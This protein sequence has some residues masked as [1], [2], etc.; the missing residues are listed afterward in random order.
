M[1]NIEKFILENRKSFD[2]A[3][4]PDGIWENI[5]A[6]FDEEQQNNR[7]QKK[8]AIRTFVS[9][10]A[11]LVMI[12]TAGILLYKTRENNKQDYSRV[13]PVLAQKQMEYSSQIVEKKEALTAM[14]ANDPQLYQEFSEVIN[15]M[16]VNYKQLK[17]EYSQSPN[18]ELTLEAMISN[19]QMQIQVLNQQLEVLNYVREQE[20]KT[21]YEHI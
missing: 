7:R 5:E 13:D 4:P 16:Q 11:M 3:L 20:K 18:K 12:C 19:L 8:L 15:K 10:A 17:N 9:I 6:S 21:P 1:G 2:D 14:A